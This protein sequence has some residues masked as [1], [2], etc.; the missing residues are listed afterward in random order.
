MNTLEYEPRTA[1]Y[2]AR[3]WSEA[4][5][6]DHSARVYYA[7]DDEARAPYI[8]ELTRVNWAFYDIRRTNVTAEEARE[9]NRRIDA[10]SRPVA[11]AALA[12]EE[13]RLRRLARPGGLFYFSINFDGVT[14]LE[15][16][17]DAHL[18]DEIMRLYHRSMDERVT[19][20]RVSGDSRAAISSTA[21]PASVVNTLPTALTNIG[22]PCPWL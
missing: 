7:A 4:C 17:I 21:S 16:Q 3:L 6:R 13:A 10:I 1:E 19:G 9:V 2:M 11:K 22:F 8:A 18:D 14:A 5:L 15:P 20:G 12:A